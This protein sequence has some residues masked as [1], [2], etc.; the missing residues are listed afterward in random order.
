MELVT[1][2]A[3]EMDMWRE[4]AVYDVGGSRTQVS[5]HLI[6][7]PPTPH[8]RGKLRNLTLMV[9][10]LG[11]IAARMGPVLL[12]RRGHPLPRA[13]LRLRRAARGG[14]AGEPAA[15]LVCAV[16]GDHEVGAAQELRLCGLRRHYTRAWH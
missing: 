16:G 11:T 12:G 4:W 7:L 14:P 15:G 5:G 3:A 9:P 13:H 2:S 10:L 1:V 6:P 8:T